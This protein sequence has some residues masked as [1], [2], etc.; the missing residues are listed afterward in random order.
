MI[1]A[2]DQGK[3]QLEKVQQRKKSFSHPAVI[4]LVFVET[5]IVNVVL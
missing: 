5:G 2:R 4:F 3:H 1:P